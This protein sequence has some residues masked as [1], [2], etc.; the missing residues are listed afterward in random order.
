MLIGLAG[1]TS[2]GKTTM[3]TAI[4]NRYGKNV[5]ILDKISRE[6]IF[7]FGQMDCPHDLTK[8]TNKQRA[9]FDMNRILLQ[10]KCEKDLSNS[11]VPVIVDGCALVKAAYAIYLSAPF[12]VQYYDEEILT[13]LIQQCIDHVNLCYSSIFYLPVTRLPFTEADHRVFK[14]KY[15]R[16]GQDAILRTLFDELD[17]HISIETFYSTEMDLVYDE[18]AKRGLR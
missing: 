6:K 18:L 3:A 2:T 14:N 9:T 1:V 16:T 17:E 10:M 15:I 4:R 12:I 13:T 5:V 7:N 11:K 8:A